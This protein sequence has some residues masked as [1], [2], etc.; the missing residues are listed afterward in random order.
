MDAAPEAGAASVAS[1]LLAFL[2]EPARFRPGYIHGDDPLPDGHVVLKFALGRFGGAYRDL[3]QED[4]A[5]L[6][7]AARAF[8]R[9][10]CLWERATHYQVL[11]LEPGAGREAIKENYRLLMALLHPDR[12]DI[13][14]REWPSGC[15]Q[16]VNDAHAVL[17]DGPARAAYDEGLGRMRAVPLF[18]RASAPSPRSAARTRPRG[19]LRPFVVVTGVLLA[20][21]I[22]QSWWVGEVPNHYTLLER[23][24]PVRASARWMSDVLPNV[25]LPRFLDGKSAY[26]FEPIEYLPPTR[27]PR[28]GSAAAWIPARA[29]EVAVAQPRGSAA[30]VAR[31]ATVAAPA[32]VAAGPEIQ[33]GP[34]LRLAQSASP[35]V[36]AAPAPARSVPGAPTTEQI[37]ILVA[38]LVSQYEAGN[39]DGLMSLFDPEELGF[40]K[41]LRTRSRYG[42][43]FRATRQRR[44][45]MNQLTWKTAPQAAQA[46]GEAV[47]VAQNADGSP[48]ERK[49]NVE[50]DIAV[51]N[52][53]ALI[54][55]LSLFPDEN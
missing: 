45:Q 47:V 37:E 36:P 43:F 44:L 22:V 38:R 10:V 4:R 11:C 2:R 39:T 51:R 54:R 17:A 9:Q 19:F 8:V 6:V 13:A 23:A 25:D 3:P 42:D 41:G 31:P 32:V 46:H 20:L 49:T 50:F 12:Q 55:H 7:E 26:V 21:F 40:W 14:A 5:E 28:L 27:P 52:G 1:Q 53:Q 33:T 35:P 30:E 16:R 24:I 29:E 34:R 48:L 18:D 15:A